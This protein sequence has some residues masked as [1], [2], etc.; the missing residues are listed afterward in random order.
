[1]RMSIP[2]HE[3]LTCTLRIL[4]T[5]R[6]LRDLRFSTAITHQALSKI[7]LDTCK[8]IYYEGKPSIFIFKNQIFYIHCVVST[9]YYSYSFYTYG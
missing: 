7:I 9:K 5:G 4:A 8:A 6:T 2:P 3:R 1:M